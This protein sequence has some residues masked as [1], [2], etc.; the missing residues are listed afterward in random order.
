MP[1]TLTVGLDGVPESR[2]AAEWAARD[3]RWRGLPLRLVHVWEGVP[4]AM[5]ESS[6]LGAETLRHWSERV[7]RAAAAGLAARPRGGVGA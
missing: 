6:V 7:A 4:D 1:R 5:A 3:A 2:A